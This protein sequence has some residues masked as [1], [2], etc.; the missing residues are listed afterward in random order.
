MNTGL[1]TDLCNIG[2]GWEIPKFSAKTR[3][4]ST[5]YKETMGAAASYLGTWCDLWKQFEKFIEDTRTTSLKPEDTTF[6][7]RRLSVL[8]VSLKGCTRSILGGFQDLSRQSSEQPSLSSALTLLWGGET[9]QSPPEVP[10][11]PRELM[12]PRLNKISSANPR[13]N[14]NFQNYTQVFQA[15]S[16][17]TSW[18]SF[19]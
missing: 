3:A 19:A 4:W 9:E 5:W 18:E 10:S 1:L 11:H 15:R 2:M 6:D 12:D 13:S 8:E 16:Y 17:S 14:L 7:S